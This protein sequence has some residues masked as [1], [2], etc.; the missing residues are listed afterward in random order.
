MLD[1]DELLV[2]ELAARGTEVEAMA[3]ALKTS[4]GAV[5]E[6]L[7]RVYRKLGGLAPG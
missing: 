6:R 3:E 5:R 4:T 2:A 1:P 7:E